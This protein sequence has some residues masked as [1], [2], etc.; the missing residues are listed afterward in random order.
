[1]NEITPPVDDR[2]N[3]IMTPAEA[4]AEEFRKTALAF[5]ARANAAEAR[6]RVLEAA[7]RGALKEMEHVQTVALREL[8]V[9]MVDVN[10]MERARAALDTGGRHG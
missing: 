5:M 2:V 6:V 1:M 7:L 9:G 4:R 3:A 8:G 10:A